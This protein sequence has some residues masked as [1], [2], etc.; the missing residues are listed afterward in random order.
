MSLLLKNVLLEQ[1]Y[2]YE[3][4]CVTHTNT[5]L[6]DL[7]IEDGYFTQIAPSITELADK[8]IDAQGQLL[9]PALRDMHIHLDKTYF[10]DTWQA[11]IKPTNGILS[12][13]E[14]ERHLLI[15][16][17]PTMKARAVKLIEHL[18]AN[19]HVHIRSHCNV[20]S[21]IGTRH[22]EM[23]H[24]VLESFTPHITYELV[25]F[26]QHGLLHDDAVNL[27]KKALQLGAT[28][29]GALNPITVDQDLYRSLQKTVELAL[30]Y[31]KGI[32]LH[33]HDGGSLGLYELRVLCDILE[34][35]AFP[36][37]VTISHA[38]A[39]A[40]ASEAELRA[41][42]AKLHQ[43]RI[44][45]TTTVPFH[46]TRRTIP[47]PT[48]DDGGIAVYVGHDS[49]MDHWSP[50]GSGSTLQKLQQLAQCFG[51]NDE[52]SI[53]QVLRYG[54][55]HITP[56]SSDGTLIWPQVGQPATAMLIDAVSSAH[57]IARICP[58]STVLHNGHVTFEQHVDLQGAYRY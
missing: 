41:I 23:L 54:T 32:D 53:G 56:L 22:I 28:H 18:I 5:A 42:M 7:L 15:K 6:F 51:Y 43:H 34:Q 49:L 17:L 16:Q 45:I 30:A 12:R 3:N 8:V 1:S 24:D 11:P 55:G 2:A 25:A 29:V 44:A 27:M 48:L 4:D 47:I 58:I 46:A 21:T 52:Q 35:Y 10:S 57:A 36:Y 19:G 14:Q 40:D 13:I 20:D 39:L 9:L 26:P 38:F 50:F 31:Q 33:L 37:D